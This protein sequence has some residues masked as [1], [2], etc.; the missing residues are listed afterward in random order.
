MLNPA[1]TEAGTYGGCIGKTSA[2]R[3][4]YRG[5]TDRSVRLITKNEPVVGR[6]NYNR[7]RPCQGAWSALSVW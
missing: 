4:R 2:A 5:H 6:N 7:A 1:V 3:C